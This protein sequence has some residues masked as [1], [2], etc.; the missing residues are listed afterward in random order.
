MRL[1][2]RITLPCT[3]GIKNAP[4]AYSMCSKHLRMKGHNRHFI[5]FSGFSP[6]FQ[7]KPNLEFLV[8]NC[9]SLSG[10]LLWSFG[11]ESIFSLIFQGMFLSWEMLTCALKAQVNE[12]NIEIA[13]WNVCITFN[14]QLF[15]ELNAQNFVKYFFFQ[16]S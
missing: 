11:R 14:L 1:R 5:H 6:R 7:P 4:Q 10:R 16:V 8:K 15:N 3:Q 9:G 12:T 13:H 2:H